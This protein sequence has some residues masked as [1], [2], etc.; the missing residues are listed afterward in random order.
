MHFYQPYTH[1]H[2]HKHRQHTLQVLCA[3]FI[4]IYYPTHKC[5]NDKESVT[6]FAMR[7]KKKILPLD[8]LRF[9]FLLISFPI[10]PLSFAYP[11]R[12]F[13]LFVFQLRHYSFL[14]YLHLSVRFFS[15]LFLFLFFSLSLYLFSST[16]SRN[17][18]LKKY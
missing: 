11:I 5:T 13:F 10:I 2:T 14:L 18:P 7:K 4:Y 8:S 3:H 1:T 15:F 9:L 17:Q 12:F 6:K 16:S